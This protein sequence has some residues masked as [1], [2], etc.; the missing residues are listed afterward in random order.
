[1]FCKS[2]QVFLHSPNTTKFSVSSVSTGEEVSFPILTAFVLLFLL[3][4]SSVRCRPLIYYHTL[5][6]QH[7]LI[8]NVWL[9][10]LVILSRNPKVWVVF[11]VW[12]ADNTLMNGTH[13]ILT[14]TMPLYSKSPSTLNQ[15]LLLICFYF[16]NTGS[17]LFSFFSFFFPTAPLFCNDSY[18]VLG[19]Y[20]LILILL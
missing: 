12:V 4:S 16:L 8:S 20:R 3:S 15:S 13:V 11:T 5:A 7:V 14:K 17:F 9:R 6:L 1:M 2:K 18:I 10:V 19:H